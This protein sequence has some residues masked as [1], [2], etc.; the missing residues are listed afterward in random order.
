MVYRRILLTIYVDDNDGD[1]GDDCIWTR[2][3][4]GKG[5][6][7]ISDRHPLDNLSTLYMK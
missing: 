6:D 2:R 4:H 7:L 3:T 1:D 5:A